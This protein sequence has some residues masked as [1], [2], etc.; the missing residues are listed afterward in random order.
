M[1]TAMSY[2]Y[3]IVVLIH[4]Q[5]TGPDKPVVH[6]QWLFWSM[7][8]LISREYMNNLSDT[9]EC[10]WFSDIQLLITS[11]PLLHRALNKGFIWI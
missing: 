2:T 3:S 6:G 7:F 9:P 4:V 10:L 1:M 11:L 8:A 5:C